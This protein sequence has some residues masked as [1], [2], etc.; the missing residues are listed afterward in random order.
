MKKITIALSAML[1]MVSLTIAS[2][3]Q[4]KKTVKPIDMNKET[5]LNEGFRL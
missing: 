3:P 2:E 4:V 5:F 1:M